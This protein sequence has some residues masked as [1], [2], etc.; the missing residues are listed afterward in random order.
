MKR[1]V[2][3]SSGRPPITFVKGGLHKSTGTPASQ[4][5]SPA[6]HRAARSG[7]LGP[8]AQKQELFDE[9][10]LTGRKPSRGPRFQHGAGH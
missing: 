1:V 7:A 3:K 6:A 4:P 5:I 9:N 8:K 2:V 10:V